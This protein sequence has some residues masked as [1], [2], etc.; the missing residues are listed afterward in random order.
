M[1]YILGQIKRKV[2]S[3]KSEDTAQFPMVRRENE[4]SLL[5]FCVGYYIHYSFLFK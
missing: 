1:H 4:V 5:C 2:E 3:Q